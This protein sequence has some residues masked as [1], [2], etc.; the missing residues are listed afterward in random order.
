M[1]DLDHAIPAD[2]TL[3]PL[4][5]GQLLVSRSH[6]VFCPVATEDVATIRDLLDG[7][8]PT[9]LDSNLW[10]QLQQH[11]FDGPPRDPEPAHPSVQIQLTNA[12]NLECTYCCTNSG[13]PRSRELTQD[14]LRSVVDAVKTQH[15]DKGRI[16][17]L[18]GE[19]LMV[20]WALDLA[21]YVMD[22]GLALTLFTNGTLLVE[23][24]GAA[25]VA[26]LQRR[27]AEVRVS[28]AGADAA[29]CDEVSGAPRFELVVQATHAVARHGGEVVVDLML[30]PQDVDQVADKMHA[31][32]RRLPPATKISLGVLYL[33]GRERG[34]HLFGSR[35]Q[36]EDALDRIA[37]E[38]GEVV[39]AAERSPVAPR[40][41]GCTCALG[42]H[43]HLR[44]DGS[45]FTCFKM[46]ERVGHLAEQPFEA[47]LADLKQR[48]RPVQTLPLCADCPL[49]T[50]CGGGCR[51]E[52]LQFT[53]D[54]DEPL[55]G[56]W[57]V[58]VLCELLAE[59]QVAALKWPA[60]HLLAEAHARVRVD[61]ELRRRALQGTSHHLGDARIVVDE[62]DSWVGPVH[63]Y[64][65]W[66]ASA[67]N[68]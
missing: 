34:H 35:A 58:R 5:S 46:E 13:P 17:L 37:F 8:Q 30:L 49:A 45:L 62:D 65:R 56:P 59:H 33:S 1:M 43:L 55:C 4:Q 50:L 24:D 18:G 23:Q 31:L 64:L 54:A 9:D 47:S 14:Q 2:S 6:A 16:A 22:Q 11:G 26:G 41:E 39:S 57:R 12:C 32:R 38:A 67:E 25:R 61:D 36:L 52:N 40:R 53:G 27:G 68:E 51:S 29:R 21:E 28:L 66:P 3:L 7:I 44:S 42:Y 48:S 10:A 20:P 15:G 60:T 63:R 19:P